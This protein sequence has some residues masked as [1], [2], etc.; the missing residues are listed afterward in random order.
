MRGS[1]IDARDDP[2]GTAGSVCDSEQTPQSRYDDRA[3]TFSRISNILYARKHPK[4]ERCFR[5]AIE[6]GFLFE[7][8]H[9]HG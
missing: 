6:I 9:G 2:A 5:R 7:F 8:K 1:G 3:W 4:Q